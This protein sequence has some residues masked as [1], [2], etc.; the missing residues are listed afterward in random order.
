MNTK[1]IPVPEGPGRIL[2]V[3]PDSNEPVDFTHF[4]EWIKPGEPFNFSEM[5]SVL[6]S[7]S[8]SLKIDFSDLLEM[9]ESWQSFVNSVG[10][11]NAWHIILYR[12]VSHGYDVYEGSDFIEIYVNADLY[13]LEASA[14]R[15][16]ERLLDSEEHACESAVPGVA[17]DAVEVIKRFSTALQAT[18]TA[19]S[20]AMQHSEKA[21]AL[22]D[23]VAGFKIWHYGQLDGT[24]YEECEEPSEGYCDSHTCL[25]DIIEQARGIK[26]AAGSASH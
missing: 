18:Q 5:Q 2:T 6:D 13:P 25:M 7:W 17:E 3:Q 11:D 15:I 16:C 24:P 20:Q 10:W 22:V 4:D 19:L 1:I 23:T 12:V 26:A 9:H 14:E 21:G 8:A